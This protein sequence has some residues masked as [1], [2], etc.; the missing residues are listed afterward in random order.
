MPW[1][2]AHWGLGAMCWVLGISRWQLGTST[3]RL[4]RQRRATLSAKFCSGQIFLLA[5]GTAIFE[6]SPAFNTKLGSVRVFAPTR[7]AIH[8]DNL[9]THSSCPLY[10]FCGGADNRFPQLCS[11]DKVQ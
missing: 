3:C 10:G 1:R 2:V 8:A 11:R 9:I 6:R 5:A 4:L 7:R